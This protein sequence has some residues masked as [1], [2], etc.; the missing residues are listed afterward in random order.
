MCFNKILCHSYL[1]KILTSHGWLAS[2]S[3]HISAPMTA[4][5]ATLQLHAASI[6]PADH[7]AACAMQMRMGFKYRQAIGELMFAAITCRPDMLFAT[8][9]LSQFS[10]HPNDCYCAAVKRVFR[11]LRSVITDGLHF[12]RATQDPTLPFILKPDS[13]PDT[14]KPEMHFTKAFAPA[15]FADA[16]WAA[17]INARRSVSGIAV[18]LAGAP[19]AYK[20]KL[21][22]AI[23]LSSTESELYAARDTAKSARCM[24]SVL[25]HLQYTIDEPA[26]IFEDNAATIAVS[27]NE[28]ATKRLRHVDLRH[29]A[30]LDWVQNGDIILRPIKTA[31][32]PS[33][34]MTKPLGKQLHFCHSDTLLGKREPN[35]C[36]Q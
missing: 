20:C 19:I 29:F 1:R 9:Y 7:T 21:Q 25:S 30:L 15:S 14:H 6:G 11:Y 33:E 18:F 22:H 34:G 23:A 10:D 3:S 5:S 4:D 36:Q 35:Y 31:D 27:H 17:N 8:I 26:P 12:W 16:D 24:R 28:R 2:S 32:N 13:H